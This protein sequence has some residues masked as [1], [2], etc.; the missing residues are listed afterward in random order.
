[1]NLAD[2]FATWIRFMKQIRVIKI[3]RTQMDQDP[4]HCFLQSVTL[5]IKHSTILPPQGVSTTVS[6]PF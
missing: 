5:Y 1:M 6:K 4:Q 3:K 2:F